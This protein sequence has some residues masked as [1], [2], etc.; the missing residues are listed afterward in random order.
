MTDPCPAFV[1]DIDPPLKRRGPRPYITIFPLVAAA[2]MNL[3]ALGDDEFPSLMLA[4]RVSG[5]LCALLAVYI[6]SGQWSAYR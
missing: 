4:C 6:A 3:I 5:V 2:T 1:V